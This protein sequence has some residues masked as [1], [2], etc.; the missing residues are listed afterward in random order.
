MVVAWF[1]AALDGGRQFAAA[2]DRY[3]MPPPSTSE[4]ASFWPPSPPK[5]AIKAV[6]HAS[7]PGH[8]SHE[9]ASRT[10][11]GHSPV[12]AIEVPS[13][14]LQFFSI[15]QFNYFPGIE[16]LPLHLKC[17]SHVTSMGGVH[18]SLDFRHRH[19][20]TVPPGWVRFSIGIEP[21]QQLCWDLYRAL[22]IICTKHK[23]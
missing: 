15:A 5:S 7:L 14:K 17:F 16:K 18:S 8:R 21:A 20:P 9:I 10:M 3:R 22:S 13:P 12:F 4:R 23:L 11:T 6:H 1:N 2:C 19:D